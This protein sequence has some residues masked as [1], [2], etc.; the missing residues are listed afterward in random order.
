MSMQN[1]NSLNLSEMIYKRKSFRKYTRE[2][3]DAKM[4]QKVTDFCKNLTPLY[5]DIMVKCEIVDKENVRCILPWSTRQVVAIF[6][7]KKDGYLENIGFMFQQLDLYLQSIGLGSCWLGMGRLSPAVR[8]EEELCFVIIL[9]FGYP[10]EELRDDLLQFRRKGISEISDIDDNRLEPA[11]LAPSSVNSQPW[12]FVHEGDT[13]HAYM[14]KGGL[15]KAVNIEDMNRIDMG[16]ALSHIYIS[17]P[18]SFKFFKS[19]SA[20]SI[21]NHLYIG[22]FCL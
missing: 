16:I 6:S 18:K 14:S 12:H 8:A 9:A 15:F 20:K 11:R 2:S 13:I 4:L 21:R 5:P 22:S 1:Y 7:E 3:V 10:K 19:D 17:N